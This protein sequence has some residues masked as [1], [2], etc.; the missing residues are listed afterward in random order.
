[1]KE[2]GEAGLAFLGSQGDIWDAQK[3]MALDML[4]AAVALLIFFVREKVQKVC[5]LI[6]RCIHSP[7]TSQAFQ[8]E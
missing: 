5:I 8:A 6:K 7:N 4:G 3:D 1:V 2:G